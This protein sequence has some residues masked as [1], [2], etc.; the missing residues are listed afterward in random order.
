VAYHTTA[1]DIILTI[2][3]AADFTNVSAGS[4]TLEVYYLT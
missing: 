1:K 3:S 4:I 2:T